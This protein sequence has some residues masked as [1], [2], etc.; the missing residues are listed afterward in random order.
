[1]HFGTQDHKT[2]TIAFTDDTNSW[3]SLISVSAIFGE[4]YYKTV[5]EYEKFKF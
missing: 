1:M 5:Q 2:V 4:D 3:Y